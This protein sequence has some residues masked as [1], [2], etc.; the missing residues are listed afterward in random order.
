[1]FALFECAEF[2][3][4]LFAGAMLK[5]LLRW[6]FLSLMTR[7]SL[8]SHQCFAFAA[9]SANLALLPTLPGALAFMCAYSC[10]PLPARLAMRVKLPTVP[11]FFMRS[12]A[13]CIHFSAMIYLP[14][15]RRFRQH[16]SLY[17]HIPPF[18]IAAELTI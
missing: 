6:S 8:V 16:P 3:Y 1:M 7:I 15:F 5:P 4:R 12:A 13:A 2:A 9:A 18:E 11:F 17:W 14:S 10:T